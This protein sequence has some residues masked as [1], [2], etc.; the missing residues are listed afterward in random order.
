RN[1]PG[2]DFPLF[3]FRSIVR[4]GSIIER[5]IRGKAQ[6]FHPKRHSLA[7]HAQSAQDGP[8]EEAMLLGHARN[9]HFLGNHLAVRLANRDAIAVWRP[10]HD[11]LHDGLTADKSLLAALK[12]REHLD[13]CEKTEKSTDGQRKPQTYLL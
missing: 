9:R 1:H 8:L 10:H 6:G 7:E 4:T 12:Y 2:R 11:A 3:G 13:M 5:S